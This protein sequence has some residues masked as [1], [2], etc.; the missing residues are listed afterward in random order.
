MRALER[1]RHILKLIWVIINKL[2]EIMTRGL[3][4]YT[5]GMFLNI[6]GVSQGQTLT[7]NNSKT[8]WNF[9]KIKVPGS[10]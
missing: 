1:D 8:I 9:R 10:N 4:G 2:K 5:M 3:H 6:L 7:L